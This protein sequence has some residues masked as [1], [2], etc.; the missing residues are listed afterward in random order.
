MGSAII[1]FLV[2]YAISTIISTEYIFIPI[3][4]KIQKYQKLYYLL[5]CPKC[6]S[7]WVGFLLSYLG[8]GISNPFFDALM[9]YTVTSFLIRITFPPDLANR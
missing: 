3:I 9:C 6:L 7:V 5:T 1:F 2:V 8:Y 4:D